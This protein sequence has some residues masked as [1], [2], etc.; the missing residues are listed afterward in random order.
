MSLTKI[1]CWVCAGF[2]LGMRW[3]CWVHAGSML[4]SRRV[5]AGFM[6]GPCWVF[7]G[8]QTLVKMK[9]PEYAGFMPGLRWDHA[10]MQNVKILKCWILLGLCWSSAGITLKIHKYMLGSCWTQHPHGKDFAGVSLGS[11]HIIEVHAGS[12]LDRTSTG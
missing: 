10:G 3:K 12:L 5:H 8:S 4:G 11:P 7:A 9:M 2:A 1:K 6:P